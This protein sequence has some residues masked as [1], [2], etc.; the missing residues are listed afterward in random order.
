MG[1]FDFNHYL[2]LFCVF[3]QLSEKIEQN[4]RLLFVLLCRWV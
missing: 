2:G 4:G 3:H 1:K